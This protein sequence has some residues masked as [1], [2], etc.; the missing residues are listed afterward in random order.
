M[1]YLFKKG[2]IASEVEQL[3][4]KTD[5]YAHQKLSL[6]TNMSTDKLA[7]DPLPSYSS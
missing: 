6:C 2:K 4:I 1:L 7:K 3:T 5:T